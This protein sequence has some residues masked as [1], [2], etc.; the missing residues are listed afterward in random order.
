M[1]YAID[2]FT[3][4]LILAARA[5]KYARYVCPVCEKGVSLRKGKVVPPYFAHLP[6]HGTSD[7]EN[8]VPGHSFIAETIKNISKRRMEL[9]LLIPV[10]C[11]SREWSLELVLPTCNLC[12][13]KITLDV[14][15][16]SQTLDM[17]SMVKSRQIGAELSV[18]SYR[19]VSYSGEPDPKFVTEVERECPGLPSDG[20]AVFTALGRGT[21]KGFPRARELR[22]TE[23][24][25]FLWKHPVA[26]VFPDELEIK[27]LSSKLGWNLALVT[28]PETLSVESISWLKCFTHLPIVPARAS[29]T[30]IWPFLNQN[31]SINQVE[32]VHAETVLLSA[33]MVSTSSQNVGP[34]MYAQGSSSLLSAVG[35][36]KSPAFFILNP[37]DSEFVGVSGSI[38]QDVNLFF[39]F[40]SNNDSPRKYPSVDLV[41]TKKNKEKIIVSLH[42]R[43]CF[44]VMMEARR[45]GHKLEYMSMPPGV[46]G[47]AR[48]QGKTESSVIKLVSS[49]DIASHDESLRLLSPVALSKLSDFLANVTYHLEIDFLGLGKIFLPSSSTLLLDEGKFIELSPDLRSRILSF[50]LQMHLITPGFSLNNDFLL[51]K[52]LF[53]L[54]P[55]SHL[56][57][58]YRAL[59]KEV[60]TN[61]FEFNRLR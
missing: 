27:S 51:V 4:T 28:I 33:N 18:N 34:T 3:G 31:T 52:K 32:C 29:I 39:S 11:N 8:F 15:G 2:K 59:V 23:T 14:G 47:V 36:E 38:E 12:R 19:I 53:C 17:R 25:A 26:P 20:A 7:C 61:G 10:G 1:N 37:G 58:H 45:L 54:Q 13:A 6:G 24:F 35:I 5:T 56:L 55:E 22:C 48:M 50:I 43:K 42:Q 41:F 57:P 9:R 44:E 21:S 40:Y 60:K 30:A 46:E 16:R 49:E